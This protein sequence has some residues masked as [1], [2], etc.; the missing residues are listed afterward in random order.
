MMETSQTPPPPSPPAPIKPLSSIL[1]KPS[2]PD[3]NLGCSYCFYL[4]KS[5]LFGETR[6]HRMSDQVLAEMIR[7]VMRDGTA[8]VSFGWQGGEPTLMGLDFFRKAVALQQQYGSPSQEV[9][10]ALQTNGMVIDDAWADFLGRYNF[11]IGLSLDGPQHVHDHYRRTRGGE[12]TWERVVRTARLL[13]N[14]RVAVNSLTVVNDYSVRFPEEIYQFHRS[15]G[16]RF[17]QFI[18][19]VEQDVANPA[20][21]A[22]FS[23]TAEA[24]GEFLCRVFD[25]WRKDFRNGRPGTSVR[26]FDSIFHTYVGAPPPECT[27][28]RECGCYVVVEHNGDVYACD[29]FVEPGWKLGNVLEGSLIEM[30]NSPR[31]REFGRM[32]LAIPEACTACPWL[33]HCH[34]GCTKDRIQ[35]PRDGGM[36]HFCKAYQIFFDYAHPTFERMAE[37]WLREQRDNLA[38]HERAAAR[39]RA[40]QPAARA[41]TPARGVPGRVAPAAATAAGAGR[42][43][44]AN[45]P[46][47]CGSGRKYKRCCGRAAR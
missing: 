26:W 10:N 22:P 43:V 15:L 14:K 35:D 30:L 7:Q 37:Q 16:L 34:G 36:T 27:L 29:F 17:M 28:L 19:C 6:R 8:S 3:C 13:M 32:K 44:G 20:A 18:P 4:Q 24:Y 47:P 12:P 5:Q 31:Q 42:P 45:S 1:V 39:Q 11:L 25:L 46:C 2:G 40:A 23:V 38:A 9:G 33:A 21:A 41:A